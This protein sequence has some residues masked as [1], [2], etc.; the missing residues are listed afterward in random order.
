M[1]QIT[2]KVFQISLGGVNVFLIDDDGLTLID[3]GFANFTDKIFA[4]V[5]KGGRNPKDIKR[6][7]LTHAHPDHSASAADIKSRLGI[8]VFAHQE[9]ALMLEQGIAGRAARILTPGIGNWLIFNLFIRPTK[10]VVDPFLVEEKLTDGDIIDVA[11]GIEVIHTPG[12]CAGHISLLVK[13]EGVLIAG[14]IC[15]N[16]FGLALSTINEDVNVAIDSIGKAAAFHFD[17]ALF[18]HGNPL[19]KDADKALRAFYKKMS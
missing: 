4:G 13:N 16:F 3:T 1:K 11:G 17:K 12:H 8:P 19:M 5:K 7:I 10:A 14:D 9:D 18:G 15:A 2:A 6:I